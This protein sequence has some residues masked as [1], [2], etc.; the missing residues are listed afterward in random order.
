[1]S[2]VNNVLESY[3][4]RWRS[5]FSAEHS[6]VVLSIFDDLVTRYSEEQRAYHTLTHIFECLSSLDRVRHLLNKPAEVELALWFHDVIYDSTRKDNEE[7]SAIYAANALQSIHID[8][9]SISRVVD[10]VRLTKHTSEALVPLTNDEKFLLDIDL[11][12]LGA[13][14]SI[15]DTYE[16][17]I[18]IEYAHVPAII[19]RYGRKK[20]L[21]KFLNKPRLYQTDYFY[22]ALDTQARLNIR[23]ALFS[24]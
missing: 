3:S 7:Q 11:A 20:L 13:P 23:R 5:L 1:M 4:A 21:N 17:N 18:R 19:F 16:K 6:G 14:P 9:N 24:L 2:D 12:I 8:V 22:N 15:Y 10:L